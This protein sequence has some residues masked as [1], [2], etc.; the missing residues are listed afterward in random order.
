M[1][2]VKISSGCNHI[3]L[4]N[5]EGDV[6]TAGSGDAGQLGRISARSGMRKNGNGKKIVAIVSHV[7]VCRITATVDSGCTVFRCPHNSVAS[8]TA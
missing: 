4:L 2:I 6:L 7:Y 3:V 8:D 5:S 1:P